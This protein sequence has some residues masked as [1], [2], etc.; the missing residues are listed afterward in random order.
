MAGGQA[1]QYGEYSGSRQRHSVFGPYG[2]FVATVAPRLSAWGTVYYYYRY[3][4]LNGT[5]KEIH[6]ALRDKVR[7]LY[8]E[9]E[10]GIPLI[11]NLISC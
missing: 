1:S 5:W 10:W 2:L 11:R 4:R 3:F 9:L 6:E 8:S 7:V